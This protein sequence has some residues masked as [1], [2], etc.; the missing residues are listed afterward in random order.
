MKHKTSHKVFY[1]S[2]DHYKLICRLSNRLGPPWNLSHLFTHLLEKGLPLL[3]ERRKDGSIFE[4]IDESAEGHTEEKQKVT[5]R[6]GGIHLD[7]IEEEMLRLS[8][9]ADFGKVCE[10]A[11][12]L[13]I[14][15]MR[16][17]GVLKPDFF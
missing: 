3:E 12:L 2:A 11:T 1:M 15:E 13:A 5:I 14:K 9:V 16:E 17:S 8:G 4:Y 7:H 6:F 10:L